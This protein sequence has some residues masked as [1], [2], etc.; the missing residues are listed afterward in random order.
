MWQNEHQHETVESK[1]RVEFYFQVLDCMT[2]QI[3]QRFSQE[4]QSLLVSFSYL[5][6]EKLLKRVNE[7]ECEGH[8]THLAEFW[9]PQSVQRTLPTLLF[10]CYTS[11]NI[12][13]L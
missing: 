9:A 3:E 12:S 1:Y 2:E 4:T 6:P 5:Q 10:I 7:Q 8:F 13:F 11:H